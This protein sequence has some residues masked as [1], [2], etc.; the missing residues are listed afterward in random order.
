[1]SKPTTYIS[2][3]LAIL[4]WVNFIITQFLYRPA[5]PMLF[6]L[7]LGWPCY[8]AVLFGITRVIA[9]QATQANSPAWYPAPVECAFPWTIRRRFHAAIAPVALI[10]F[11]VIAFSISIVAVTTTLLHHR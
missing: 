3:G 1:M 10:S 6:I 2:L 7:T 9:W 5:D 11:S 8:Y 4:A